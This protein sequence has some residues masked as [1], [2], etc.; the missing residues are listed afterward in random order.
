[1][2]FKN[3]LVLVACFY[4]LAQAAQ[5][6]RVLHVDTALVEYKIEK[7]Q[8]LK[9]ILI[10]NGFNLNEWYD[11]T[12]KVNNLTRD[13][14][15]RVGQ[16]ILIPKEV[17]YFTNQKTSKNEISSLE[18]N[19]MLDDEIKTGQ[20]AITRSNVYT[21]SRSTFSLLDNTAHRIHMN[22]FSFANSLQ[23]GANAVTPY[24][25]GV[26]YAAIKDL[27]AEADQ[28]AWSN[29][30][31]SVN[32]GILT[33]ADISRRKR[34]QNMTNSMRLQAFSTFSLKNIINFKP[35]AEYTNQDNITATGA[36]S[37]N[38]RTDRTLW[39]GFGLNKDFYLENELLNVEFEFAHTFISREIGGIDGTNLRGY[40][41]TL[42]PEL[43]IMDKTF[44]TGI[45]ER[46]YFP[47][48]D[49]TNT[50]FGIGIGRFL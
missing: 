24:N 10:K 40:R 23:N 14:R 26:N 43:T 21:E 5:A 46:S 9:S 22:L 27:Q 33:E 3:L 11:R 37:Y 7:P 12:L 2:S 42:K 41:F 34:D 38:A 50:T 36:N 6:Q 15:L 8:T 32:F 30:G 39:L 19:Q 35:L 13:S 29:F 49:L 18:L 48:N 31:L 44:L 16:T 4:I 17:S 1:M 28:N 25:I 47:R 45:A 20:A